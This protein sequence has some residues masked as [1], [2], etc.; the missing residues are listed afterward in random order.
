M[1]ATDGV[2]P[3][4]SSAEASADGDGSAPIA[5]DDRDAA[6][7]AD[8]EAASAR[9]AQAAAPF[10]GAPAGSSSSSLGNLG[11]HAQPQ[12][13]L[14]SDFIREVSQ[15][16]FPERDN[17]PGLKSS[18][19]LESIPCGQPDG[20]LTTEAAIEKAEKELKSIS[21]MPSPAPPEQESKDAK[22]EEALRMALDA[23][24]VG[25]R[26]LLGTA[27]QRD[28]PKGSEA[29]EH[30]MTLKTHLAKKEFRQAWAQKQFD[31]LRESKRY[32][33]SH[34]EV[35][36]QH[37]TYLPFR[38]VWEAEGMDKPGYEALRPF[39]KVGFLKRDFQLSEFAEGWGMWW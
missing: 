2:V 9:K 7:V 15:E 24:D 37:G 22:R 33:Q 17:K 4:P 3:V 21:P 8:S 16:L 29:Y 20:E 27:F 6:E 13:T 36:L 31:S 38:K 18:K 28:H 1:T 32:T 10:D 19:S 11:G 26:G 25:S 35:N 5:L 34:R 14:T 30:Y 23:G 12:F 39:L